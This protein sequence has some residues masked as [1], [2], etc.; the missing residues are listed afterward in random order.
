MYLDNNNNFRGKIKDKTINSFLKMN[1]KLDTTEERIAW[2]NEVFEAYDVDGA[3]FYH[4]YW[5]EIFDQDRKHSKID[6][7]IG[8][9][10]STY[11]TS[12]IASALEKVADYILKTDNKKDEHERKYVIYNSEELFNK[13]CK[14]YNITSSIAR[15]NSDSIG[16]EKDVDAFPFFQLPQ[17][18]NKVK[19]LKI[20]KEDLERFQELKDYNDFYE[21]LKDEN[22]R[23]W[24]QSN[25]SHEELKRK[26]LIKK[27]MPEIKKDMR[28]KK[29][30][31]EL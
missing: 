23:L 22:N 14:E 4:E 21:Y 20:E 12:N 11:S 1:Y 13:A 10:T 27:V 31:N 30:V 2:V 8:K 18:Y 26:S 3:T 6:I 25:L 29:H 7:V 28:R 5:D 19:D 16:D 24:S 9:C 15:A 17:N